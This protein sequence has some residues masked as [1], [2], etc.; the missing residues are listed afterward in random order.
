MVSVRTRNS[1]ATFDIKSNSGKLLFS[2]VVFS[3][4][5]FKR[6]CLKVGRAGRSPV[7]RDPGANHRK[8]TS[9]TPV[10]A[11]VTTTFTNVPRPED[12]LVTRSSVGMT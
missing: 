12:Q 1:L 9:P 6:P 3:Q 2:R 8:I 5:S 10:L 4:Q 7:D 11:P